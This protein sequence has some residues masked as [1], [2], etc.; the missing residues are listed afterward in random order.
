MRVAC[1]A[2]LST[3]APLACV[4]HP[5]APVDNEVDHR[6]YTINIHQN[7]MARQSKQNADN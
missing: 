6:L 2:S 1:T 3:A 4:G 5:K 7:R